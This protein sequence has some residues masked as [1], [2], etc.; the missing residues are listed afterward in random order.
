M[1]KLLA[2]LIALFSSFFTTQIYSNRAK[3]HLCHSSANFHELIII[4][5]LVAMQKH[6]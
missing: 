5:I 6:A 2:A 1:L 4:A 3:P